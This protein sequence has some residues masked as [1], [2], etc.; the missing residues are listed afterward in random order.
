MRISKLLLLAATTAA[1]VTACGGDDVTTGNE[2]EV[3]TTI[4]LTFTPT[5]GGPPFTAVWDDPDGDGGAA[6]TIDTIAVGAGAAYRMTVTFQNRLVDPP[7]D[8]TTEV[9]DEGV[10][11]QLF[12]TGTAVDGPASDHPGAAL[13]QAYADADANGLPLGLAND[14]TVAPAA[15]GDLTVTLRHLPPVN[16]TAV[17]TADLAATVKASGVDALPGQSDAHVTFPVAVAVP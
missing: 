13:A 3:I 8:I 12:F 5:G 15:G 11:H 16:G 9:R 14:L 6:P 17:K 10:Q 2:G 4:T 7:E 1:L